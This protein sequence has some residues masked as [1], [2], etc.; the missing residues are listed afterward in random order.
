MLSL[1]IQIPFKSIE[2]VLQPIQNPSKING[3]AFQNASNHLNSLENQ[4]SPLEL[5][6]G[7]ASF[8]NV[9]QGKAQGETSMVGHGSSSFL[10]VL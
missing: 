3:A 2:N 9:F 7:S 8:L 5:G 4:A 1:C 10:K 6:H